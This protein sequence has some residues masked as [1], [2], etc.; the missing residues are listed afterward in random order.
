ML[1][2]L[3][4]LKIFGKAYNLFPQ[5]F[6]CHMKSLQYYGKFPCGA[7]IEVLMCL[8]KNGWNSYTTCETKDQQGN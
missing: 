7:M 4:E 5:N 3:W 2:I 1:R 6:P 8:A